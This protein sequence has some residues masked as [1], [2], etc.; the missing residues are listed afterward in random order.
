MELHF[1]IFKSEGFYIG[2]IK[3][4]PAVNTQGK[5]RKEVKE[6]LLDALKLYLES[7]A[8]EKRKASKHGSFTFN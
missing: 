3:E 4:Y 5:T 1:S 8:D 7:E 2:T 6:N